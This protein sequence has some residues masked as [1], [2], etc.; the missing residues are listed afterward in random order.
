MS[1]PRTPL[2]TSSGAP[3]FHR[4][5]RRGRRV[6]IVV[7]ALLLLLVLGTAG[8]GWYFANFLVDAKREPGPFDDR[9]TGTGE[10]RASFET[11]ERSERP[12]TYGLDWR[13]GHAFVGPLLGRARD[14][15]VTRQLRD[16]R[17]RLEDD[18]EVE[19]DVDL[20]GEAATPRS[21]LDIPYRRV[22]VPTELGPAPAWLVSPAPRARRRARPDTWAIVVHGYKGVPAEGLR[23]L[24]DLRAAGLTSLL[25]TYRND[26]GAPRSPDGLIHLGAT[27]WRDLQSAAAYARRRGARR[28]VLVGMSMGGAIVCQFFHESRL[29][30]VVEGLILDAPV[31]DWKAV[32]SYQADQLHLPF[33]VTDTAEAIVKARIDIDYAQFDQIARAKEFDLPILLFHGTGDKTVPVETSNEFARALPERVTYDRVPDAA[34]VGSWNVDPRAYDRRVRA[35]LRR[36][37]GRSP[38]QRK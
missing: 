31:L 37:A 26:P 35:F 7:G 15:E 22:E 16:P 25:I 1:T 18:T 3:L 4:R 34:H 5:R 28:L 17:G 14:G 13:R 36:V 32:L 33:F 29:A 8:A 12:G 30:R 10:G 21:A 24:P 2:F 6:L 23:I 19:F 11:S 20:Y 9:L 38:S 27:E